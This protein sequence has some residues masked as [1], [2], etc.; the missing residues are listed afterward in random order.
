MIGDGLTYKYVV[1]LRAVT[2]TD[3]MTADFTATHIINEVKRDGW[4]QRVARMRA[5]LISSAIPI[6]CILWR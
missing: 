2:S 5:P 1:G 3:G 4:S 6:N